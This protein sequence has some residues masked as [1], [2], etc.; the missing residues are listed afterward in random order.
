MNNKKKNNNKI[1][2]QEDERITT[3]QIKS[4]FKAWDA[5]RN[6]VDTEQGRT[7]SPGV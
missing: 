3:R 2:T 5:L 1:N 4:C 6:F 7:V